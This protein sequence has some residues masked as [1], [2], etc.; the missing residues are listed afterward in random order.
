V[1][2]LNA[3]KQ[4]QDPTQDAD[5]QPARVNAHCLDCNHTHSLGDRTRNPE[6]AAATVCPSCGS[7]S[8]R[9]EAADDE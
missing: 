3:F 2:T 5:E 1:T 7:T 4:R 6:T 9:S 8:Y